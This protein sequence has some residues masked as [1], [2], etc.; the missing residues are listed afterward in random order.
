MPTQAP[1]LA[2]LPVS[3]AKSRPRACSALAL[4]LFLA[5][6][7]PAAAAGGFFD[8]FSGPVLDPAWTV[9]ETWPGGTARAHG[10]TAPANRFSLSENPG[11]LRYSLDPMTH[12]DGFL[13]GYATTFS[14]HSCCNHDAGL[15]LHR[16]VSGDQWV[17]ETGGV[18]FLPFANGRSFVVRIYFGTG[19]VPTY[20]VSL[21][22]GAD[23]NHN[24]V[25]LRLHEKTGP[26]LG[27]QTQLQ[28]AMPNGSWYYG[29][30]NYPTAPLYFRVERAGG[31]LTASSSDDGVTWST[32]WSHDFGT[33]LGGLD[34]RL[35]LTGQSWFVPAGSYAD[36]DYVSL[37]PSE[38]QVALDVKPGSDPNSVNPRSKGVIPVAILTTSTAD[39]D[40][41]D[42][43]AWD[44]DPLSL[45][46]GPDGAGIAHAY[47]HAEDVDGDGDLDMVVHFRTRETG[48]ACGDTEAALSGRTLDG[49][50]IGGVGSIRTVGCA[51]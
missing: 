23:V 7:P 14:F 42:F 47:A 34:Q 43:D 40:A 30:G 5:L 8:D 49:V 19:E 12:H 22:R 25:L 26:A 6:A 50:A 18:F 51:R 44:I 13:N 32:A 21:E 31:V 16:T 3:S 41:A 37:I 46:F 29:V 15:E 11:F 17:F 10:F 1:V 4:V 39:G 35:V 2:R 38:L 28:V 33:A 20:W 36:W 45:A 9:V 27:D 48:I 24:F